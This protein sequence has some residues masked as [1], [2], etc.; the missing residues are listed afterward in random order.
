M[1]TDTA[2]SNTPLP[3]FTTVYLQTEGNHGS[4]YVLAIMS[5]TANKTLIVDLSFQLFW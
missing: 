4:F 2:L 5:K 3:G 1:E